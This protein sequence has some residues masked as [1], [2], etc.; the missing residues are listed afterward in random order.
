MFKKLLASKKEYGNAARVGWFLAL[1]QIRRGGKG[2][3][4]LIVFI[5][6][7]TFLNLVVVSGL[8]IGLITGSYGQYREGYSGD[9]IITTAPGRDY[10]ENS[11]G[12]IGFLQSHPWVTTFSPRYAV[13]AQILGTLDDLPNNKEQANVIGARLT[14]IDLEK[15]EAVTRFSRFVVYGKTLNPYEEGY[16]LLGANLLTKY[17]SFADAN[18]PG[19]SFLKDVDIGSRVR[20]SITTD[21]QTTKKDF[22]VAG[23][24]KSKIDEISTRAFITDKELKRLLPINQEQVQEIA[25]RTTDRAKAPLLVTE[26]KEY[27]GSS[28]ARIQTSEE[29]IPSFLRDIESTM[30]ILGNALSSFALIVAAITIFIVIFIN[31]VTKRK[32][33]GIMKGIGISPIAIQLSY[34]IQ[35][36]FYGIAGSTIG[37][38]LTF[39][40][41]R[42][43][44]DANPI[45]FPFS[46]GIL[47]V[48]G[49]GA[50]V[51]AEDPSVDTLH[52][53]LAAPCDLAAGRTSAAVAAPVH[54]A[55]DRHLLLGQH[56]LVSLV[57]RCQTQLFSG[58]TMKLQP[59]KILAPKHLDRAHPHKA[60]GFLCE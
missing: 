1:R 25:I 40:I 48:T 58:L 34:I 23:I 11:Q 31:A 30:G 47:A 5:M 15:E 57:R 9:V 60:Q 18:I 53:P 20:V 33:I 32:F 56:L 54:L 46:D 50:G 16:I 29:A 21:G 3:T 2:T 27:M 39:L 13:T 12:L 6:V 26:I 8:L 55:S 35:A 52:K 28:A 24:V 44:F 41:L 59:V 7:L 10:I 17:S 19:L 38:L 4:A 43:Y 51:R 42:P 37:L 49:F 14:G 22:I 36:I 45:N